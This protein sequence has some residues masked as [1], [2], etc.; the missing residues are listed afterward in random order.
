[1]RNYY[2]INNVLNTSMIKLQQVNFIVTHTSFFMRHYV[3]YIQVRRLCINNKCKFI[4]SCD[5][6]P[7]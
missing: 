2:N 6:F 1:M 7:I 4:I 3:H 5:T